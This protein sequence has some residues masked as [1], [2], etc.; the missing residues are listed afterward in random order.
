MRNWDRWQSYRRDRPPP[1]WIK[2]HRRLMMDQNWGL[3]TDS[4]KGALVSIWLIAADKNG[5]IPDDPIAVKKLAMLDLEPPLD[6][7]LTLQFLEKIGKRRRRNSVPKINRIADIAETPVC[8]LPNVAER[9]RVPF[10]EIVNIY[11]RC[12]PQLP[13]VET[14]TETRR[15]FLRAR[16][17][18][19]PG[20]DRWETFFGIVSDSPFLLGKSAPRNGSRPFRASFDWLIRPTNFVKVVEHHYDDG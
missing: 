16:W 3:L 8:P 5:V 4:E 19:M 9:T 18:E 17:H 7:L 10:T 6:K 20:L 14:L 15:R 13:R 1:P 12:C 11:H 2:L